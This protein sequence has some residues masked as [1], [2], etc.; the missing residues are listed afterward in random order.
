MGLKKYFRRYAIRAVRRDFRRACT[1]IAYRMA[2]A[3][4]KPDEDYIAEIYRSDKP[5][6]VRAYR[7]DREEYRAYG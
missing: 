4:F 3:C 7:K 5:S 2:D 1:A 6:L